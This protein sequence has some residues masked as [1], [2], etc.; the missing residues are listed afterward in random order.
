MIQVKS[1]QLTKLS[2]LSLI[3]P[4][5]FEFL[6][7]I[8]LLGIRLSPRKNDESGRVP[9]MIQISHYQIDQPK[10]GTERLT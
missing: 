7:S 5:R 1:L 4:D 8:P 9:L 2:L 6:K 10:I 3:S